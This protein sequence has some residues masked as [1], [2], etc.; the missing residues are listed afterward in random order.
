MRAFIMLA[1]AA[2]VFSACGTARGDDA[3]SASADGT[4][5]TAAG[6]T[7]QEG[8]LPA[9]LVGWFPLEGTTA[10][11]ADPSGETDGNERVLRTIEI[12][13]SD[14]FAVDTVTMMAEIRLPAVRDHGGVGDWFDIV[15]Y[16]WGGPILAVTG[17]GY[18]LAGL[19]GS[20]SCEFGA[21]VFVADNQWHHVATTHDEADLVRLFVDGEQ[22]PVQRGPNDSPFGV[23]DGIEEPVDAGECGM[24]ASHAGEKLFIGSDDGFEYFVGDIRNVRVYNRALEPGEIAAL[25]S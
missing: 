8:S 13:I 15:S 10:N 9:G 11:H 14:Q 19:Q 21:N 3:Q 16:G 17:D 20:F 24:A 1:I 12:P 18:P 5:V 22:V 25:A 2:V 7:T 23:P 6:Q 4:H